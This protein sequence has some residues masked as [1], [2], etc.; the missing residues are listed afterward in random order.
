MRKMFARTENY[1]NF[2]SSVK[3]VEQRGAAEAGKMLVYG[4][5]GLGKSHVVSRWAAEAGAI[6]LRGNKDWTPRYALSEL[7]VHWR[8]TGAATRKS[9]HAPIEADCGEPVADHH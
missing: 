1:R 3:A 8:L 6:F 7:A 2:A 9:F 4:V 5:L